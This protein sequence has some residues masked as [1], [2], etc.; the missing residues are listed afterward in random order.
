MDKKDE[1]LLEALVERLRGKEISDWH[2]TVTRDR[3]WR[4]PLLGRV[5]T[6]NYEWARY[7]TMFDSF[8]AILEREDHRWIETTLCGKEDYC[9]VGF[10]LEVFEKGVKVIG[11]KGNEPKSLYEK[12]DKQFNEYCQGSKERLREV[13]GV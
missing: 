4:E 3:F 12:I 9:K 8:K 10:Q 6:H 11:F 7:S 5:V 1:Q 2:R 13:L